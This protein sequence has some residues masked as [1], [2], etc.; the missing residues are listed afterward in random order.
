MIALHC[1]SRKWRWDKTETKNISYVFVS[2]DVSNHFS[3]YHFVEGKS[4]KNLIKLSLHI[5][6]WTEKDK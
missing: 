1:M 6:N 2:D 3:Q 4:N 5:G